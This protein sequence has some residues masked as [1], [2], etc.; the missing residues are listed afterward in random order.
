MLGVIA[1]EAPSTYHDIALDAHGGRGCALIIGQGLVLRQC[2]RIVQNMAAWAR[3][4][5]MSKATWRHWVAVG[6]WCLLLLLLLLLLLVAI[7]RLDLISMCS[8]QRRV[9]IFKGAIIMWKQIAVLI[10][11]NEVSA[12]VSRLDV[13]SPTDNT[14]SLS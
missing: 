13:P 5:V 10:D 8:I 7:R 1:S 9:D 3:S 12:S 11:R 4:H 14:R 6:P 2:C